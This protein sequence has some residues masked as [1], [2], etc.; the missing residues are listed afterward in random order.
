[1]VKRTF[2]DMCGKEIIEEGTE[3]ESAFIGVVVIQEYANL[4]D[5]QRGGLWDSHE[6]HLCPTHL[7]EIKKLLKVK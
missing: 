1:M 2:C 4:D 5:F 7:K 6:L 3:E